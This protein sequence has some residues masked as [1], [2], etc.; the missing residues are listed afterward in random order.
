MTDARVVKACRET[1][2]TGLLHPLSTRLRVLPRSMLGDRTIMLCLC[3]SYGVLMLPLMHRLTVADLAICAGRA[4]MRTHR[5]TRAAMGSS[6]L[7]VNGAA[8]GGAEMRGSAAA[9]PG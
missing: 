9:K 8:T 5:C 4:R 6:V 2:L 1:A 7:E 3:G